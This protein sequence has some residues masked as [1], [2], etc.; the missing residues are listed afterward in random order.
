MNPTIKEA[1]WVAGAGAIGGLLGVLASFVLKQSFP[2]GL[3]VAF[4]AGPV[5]GGGAG[6][7][8]VYLVANSDR[9]ELIRCL[10]FAMVCGIA[11]KP[12]FDAGIAVV[13]QRANVVTAERKA[14]QVWDVSGDLAQLSGNGAAPGDKEKIATKLE[15]ASELVVSSL[16]AS[17]AADNPEAKAAV[18][19]SFKDLLKSGAMLRSKELLTPEGEVHLMRIEA[20]ARAASE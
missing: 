13:T 17:R 8:G 11:W 20:T 18:K 15:E 9:K 4:A 5:L 7:I 16:T 3:A 14:E 12:V 6:L 10:V 19:S 2:A 1:L